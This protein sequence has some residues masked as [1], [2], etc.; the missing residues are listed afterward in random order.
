MNLFKLKPAKLL[1][2]INTTDLKSLIQTVTHLDQTVGVLRE[3]VS[4]LR[5]ELDTLKAD[6][7]KRF[8]E[9]KPPVKKPRHGVSVGGAFREDH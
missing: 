2:S 5:V 7:Q 3:T 8:Y 9:P 6:Y 4:R 1:A